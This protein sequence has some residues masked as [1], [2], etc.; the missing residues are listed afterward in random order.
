MSKPGTVFISYSRKDQRWLERLIVH[1]RP[2]ER[3]GL[4]D[5]WSD[6]KL[7]GGV[8]WREELRGA[9]ASA[10]VAILLVS[11][12]FFASEFITTNELPP[13]LEKARRDGTTILSV[14]VSPCRFARSPLSKYQ[15]MNDPARPL[16]QMQ[17]SGRER[18]WVRIAERVEDVVSGTEPTPPSAG[19]ADVATSHVASAGLAD[20]GASLVTYGELAYLEAN[21]ND[22]AEIWIL[23]SALLLEKTDLE[24]IILGNLRKGVVYKYILPEAAYITS[25]FVHLARQWRRQAGL[26]PAAAGRQ[27]QARCV[28]AC[29][30]YMTV[31]IYDP[32]VK[33]VVLVKFPHSEVYPKNQYP[34]IYRVSSRPGEE[35]A[36]NSFV[37]S[38]QRMLE[39][40]RF[41]KTLDIS[42]DEDG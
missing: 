35:A 20:F 41:G 26:S 25:E 15:S 21:V 8:K 1:L 11:A 12:D 6:K 7:E 28:P 19:P 16:V 29:F 23:T 30:T 37:D 32:L 36:L 24:D 42:Y 31:I 9:L 4:V 18:L 22:R 14:I 38:L 27:I 5:L 3:E 33:P 40:A 34:F 13:L 2:L 17:R 10:Q 39:D